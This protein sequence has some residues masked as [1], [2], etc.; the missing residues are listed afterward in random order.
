MNSYY[1]RHIKD[2]S[3]IFITK[4]FQPLYLS[5]LKQIPLLSLFLRYYKADTVYQKASFVNQNSAVAT[6]T[7]M[8]QLRS[9][10][11]VSAMRRCINTQ[12]SSV[13]NCHPFFNKAQIS[14]I[15]ATY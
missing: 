15:R 12:A 7:I 2:I 4:S 14:I 9:P 5:I 10:G 1:T 6:A 3:F 8:M 13:E 11:Y